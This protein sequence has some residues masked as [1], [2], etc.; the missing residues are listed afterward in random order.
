M[1]RNV[2]ALLF[3]LAAAV[4]VYVRWLRPRA[5][6]WGAT[7]EE[8]GMALPFDGEFANPTWN[9]TRAVTVHATPEQ[10]W[11][12]LV[13]IG[14]GRAGWYGYDW[15]DN[16][17]KPSAWEILPELQDIA[18]GK[19]FP[20]SPWTAMRCFAFEENRWMLWRVNER[21]GTFVWCLHPIDATSTRLIT[22]MRD[23]YRWT[24]PLV[25]PQQLAVDLLDV[26]FMRKCMLGVKARAERMAA[27]AAQAS[28][29]VS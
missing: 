23:Q 20:M 14:C 16:G 22:R 2:F 4:A 21:A 27:A 15:V 3:A 26:F 24:N 13:Q 5:M 28:Q 10:I 7:T 11:P 6:N 18:V 9:A 1:I 8:S 12:W 25:L 29:S 17:G 19:E